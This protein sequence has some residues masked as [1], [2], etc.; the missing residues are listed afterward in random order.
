MRAGTFAP[1]QHRDY[2]AV[3]AALPIMLLLALCAVAGAVALGGA[4][5][6]GAAHALHAPHATAVAGERAANAPKNPVHI[7]RCEDTPCSTLPMGSF[8]S[9][10]RA[11]SAL[12]SVPVD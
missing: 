2:S 8:A 6:Q 12:S 10:C 9:T 5:F 3:I 7:L 1:S 11:S 4:A